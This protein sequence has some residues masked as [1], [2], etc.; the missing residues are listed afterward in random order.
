MSKK[1]LIWAPLFFCL[2][3]GIIGAASLYFF[4]SGAQKS[5]L[6]EDARF[7]PFEA[8]M[9]K[10]D[11][12]LIPKILA[13]KLHKDKH[14]GKIKKLYTQHILKGDP[15]TA[16]HIPKIIHQ[17]WLGGPLPEKYKAIQASWRKFHPDWEYR[18]WTDESVKEFKMQNQA[19]FDSAVNWGEKADILR[20]EILNQFGGL[21]VD[22]DF[23][24][25]RAFDIL[26][27]LCDFYIGLECI[28]QRFQSPRMSN[29]LIAC[30]PA[31]PLIR[32]CINSISGDGPRDNCDL[33]QARTGPGLVTRVFFR[34]L[35]DTSYKNVALPST[36]FYP[37]PASERNGT[38]GGAIKQTWVQDESFAIHYW[39]GSW[40][41]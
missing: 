35:D 30:A 26:H 10:R 4:S 22:T 8:S 37:L 14:W 31:H 5:A 3:V 19:L 33:I 21:Y 9:A 25:L 17:I 16:C 32:E 39:D 7:I 11:P 27:H 41:P 1:L 12:S 23:E 15:T 6:L 34:F 36:Y 13:K 18:L 29:A 24:C 40:I 2:F 38:F 28:E 20:Y